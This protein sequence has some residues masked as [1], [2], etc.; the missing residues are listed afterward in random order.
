MNRSDYIEVYLDPVKEFEANVLKLS[1]GVN[2]ADLLDDPSS[3]SLTSSEIASPDIAIVTLN[4]VGT[5]TPV[6]SA[7]IKP[8][9]GFENAKVRLAPGTYDVTAMLICN[10]T[11]TIP[12]EE[13]C[14]NWACTEKQ[15]IPEQNFEQYVYNVLKY[16]WEVSAEELYSAEEI[17]FYIIAPPI[18][19]SWAEMR[20]SN[21]IKSTVNSELFYEQY[22]PKLE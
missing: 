17:E 9:A 1:V 19:S 7:I 21:Q 22:K 3:V 4:M 5:E 2:L 18:P 15:E 14:T 16:Q 11:V 6:A 13:V 10:S 8:T 12:E 20:V